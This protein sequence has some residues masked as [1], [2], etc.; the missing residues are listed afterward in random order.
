[1][2]RSGVAKLPITRR[3]AEN[4]VRRRG[5]RAKFKEDNRVHVGGSDSGG[6]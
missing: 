4:V 3:N 2:K 5:W 6:H 1:M